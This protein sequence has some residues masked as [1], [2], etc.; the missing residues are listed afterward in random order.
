MRPHLDYEDVIYHTPACEFSQ[1]II[2]PNLM[3]KLKAV[4][5]SAAQPVTG[6]WRGTSREK[7][8]AEIGWESLSSRRW[9]RRMTLF[10]EIMN[11]LTPLYTKEPIPSPHQ[12]QYSLRN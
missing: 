5:Y 9:S 3:E 11:D 4:P 12:S 8:Y 1:N 10:Y 7:L 2:L 6:T